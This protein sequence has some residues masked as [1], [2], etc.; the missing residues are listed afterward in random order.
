MSC[1][2]LQHHWEKFDCRC[3][4]ASVSDLRSNNDVFPT[5]GSYWKRIREEMLIRV[6]QDRTVV[7]Y[8]S[9]LLPT[10]SKSVLGGVP[11]FPGLLVPMETC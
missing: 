6:L 10:V 3:P 4:C 11:S 7:G 8:I 2:Y 5:L 9:V 1:S